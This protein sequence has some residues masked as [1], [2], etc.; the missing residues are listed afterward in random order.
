MYP[1]ICRLSLVLFV[2]ESGL[3]QVVKMEND[4]SAAVLIRPDFRVSN[5]RKYVFAFT[6]RLL[7]VIE[8]IRE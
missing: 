6:N 4:K 8:R 7:K 1:S 2:I 5:G 3:A